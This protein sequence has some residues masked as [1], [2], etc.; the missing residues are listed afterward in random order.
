M[1]LEQ[2]LALS[3]HCNME[4]FG[5]SMSDVACTEYG[6]MH[7]FYE[8]SSKRMNT[9]DKYFRWKNMINLLEFDSYITEYVF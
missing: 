7:L 9:E 1:S 6:T 8:E 4:A 2:Q 3:K 5:S